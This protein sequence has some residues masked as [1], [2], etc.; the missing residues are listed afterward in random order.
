MKQNGQFI[1]FPEN[2]TAGT[3]AARR[4][5]FCGMKKTQPV[6]GIPPG[7]AQPVLNCLVG[8]AVGLFGKDKF[9]GAFQILAKKNRQNQNCVDC[10]ESE[11]AIG[12]QKS[13]MHRGMPPATATTPDF[14]HDPITAL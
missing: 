13:G 7:L 1:F 8:R 5:Q 10:F 11:L 9:K 2:G 3:E 6:I 4:L 14:D 12:N